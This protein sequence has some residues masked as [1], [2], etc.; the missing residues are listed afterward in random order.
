MSI[1]ETAAR[2]APDPLSEPELDYQVLPG[3]LGYQIRRTQAWIFAQFMAELGDLDLTPGSFGMLAL[4]QANPG[5]TQNQL[6]RAFGIDKSTLTPALNRLEKRGLILREP[7]ANDRRFNMLR[8]APEAQ[9]RI[10]EFLDRV[11]RFEGRMTARLGTEKAAQLIALLCEL[12]GEGED[13]SAP[14]RPA[15]E[16]ERA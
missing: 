1:R 5:I 10:D 14:P 9:A 13:V 15:E 4:V 8:I 16:P 3:F 6:A 2:R 7:L 12:R 11:A